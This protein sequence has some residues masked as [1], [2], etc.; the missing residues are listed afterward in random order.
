MSIFWNVLT[1]LRPLGS[2]GNA[3]MHHIAELVT[4]L[5]INLVR[6]ATEL[7]HRKRCLM[8]QNSR[9]QRLDEFHD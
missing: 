8:L 4:I 7:L 6:E 5:F 2:G 9:Q 3:A 1:T